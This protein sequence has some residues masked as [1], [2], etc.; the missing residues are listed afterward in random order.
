M[1]VTAQEKIGMNV[2]LR[3]N[4]RVIEMWV[5]GLE[6]RAYPHL[7]PSDGRPVAGNTD[8]EKS[9]FAEIFKHELTRW[10]TI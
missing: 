7:G 2:T 9:L 3:M 1:I 5:R 10:S 4:R 6:A 8:R